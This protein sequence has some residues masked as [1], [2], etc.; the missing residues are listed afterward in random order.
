[1]R[2]RRRVL[3][4]LPLLMAPA[5]GRATP[6]IPPLP[7]WL[8][9]TALLPIESATAR[10]LL[11]GDGT[12][13]MTVR[14]LFFCRALPIHAWQIAGD[15]MTVRYTRASALDPG[16]IIAGEAHILSTE[17]RLLWVEAARHLAEFEGFVEPALA[18]R[19]S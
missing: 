9:G 16:R 15:G 4:S 3:L 10:L 5:I 11:A 12:G 2:L 19:C 8:G 6:A 1:M 13:V 18:G 17:G 14:L 7:A